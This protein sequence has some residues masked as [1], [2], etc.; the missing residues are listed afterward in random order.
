MAKVTLR[1]VGLFFNEEVNI[2]LS[3][4]LTVRNVVDEYIRLNPILA[5]AGG[6]EYELET[7]T[8]VK[9]FTYNFN[10]K[11]NYKGINP[12]TGRTTSLGGK[13]RAAGIYTLSESLTREFTTANVFLTWQ[14]YVVSRRG[15]V[16]SK[17]PVNRGF[18]PWGKVP[19]DYTIA[20]GDTIIW[21]LVAIV[22]A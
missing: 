7:D 14:Y 3:P 21:R 8:T 17:T 2:A 6:L 4:N 10:G 9:S 22:N 19:P 15:K 13:T 12:V 18:K 20:D 16:K 1:I 11:F 5:N